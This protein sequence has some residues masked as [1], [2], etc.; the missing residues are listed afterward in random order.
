MNKYAVRMAALALAVLCL[1]SGCKKKEAEPVPEEKN[2][3]IGYAT[4]GVAAIDERTLNDAV[5][6]MYEEA[7]NAPKITLQFQNDAYSDD[8]L[9]FTCSIGN[10]SEN[11]Y[12]MFI[13]IYPE[14][15]EADPLFVSQLLRP[16]QKFEHITLDRALEPGTHEVACAF[17]Q[18]AMEDGEQ[19]IVNQQLIALTFHVS[20]P[21]SAPESEP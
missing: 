9:N 19:T 16:G 2:P 3:I 13:A 10:S 17:T 5:R 7:A 14:T 20:E 6:E 12:D 21:D 18:V 1:M 4:E 15:G 11:E 8:G